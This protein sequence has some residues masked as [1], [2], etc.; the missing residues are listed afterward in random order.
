MCKK[1]LGRY[2]N[3][4]GSRI[5][6]IIGEFDGAVSFNSVQVVQIGGTFCSLAKFFLLFGTFSLFEF[7][8]KVFS[9]KTNYKNFNCPIAQFSLFHTNC[10]F[11]LGDT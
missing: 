3:V 6:D 1:E 5:C 4:E 7:L 10:K 11:A 9:Y 8:I 2:R